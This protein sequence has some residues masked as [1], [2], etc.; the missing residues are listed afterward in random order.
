MRQ[1]TK[2]NGLVSHTTPSGASYQSGKNKC[3]Q[4]IK[5]LQKL[6]DEDWEITGAKKKSSE[7]VFKLFGE[8][9]IEIPVEILIKARFK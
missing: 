8:F 3:E 1:R 4:N 2:M 6:I 7:G 9:T 5:K